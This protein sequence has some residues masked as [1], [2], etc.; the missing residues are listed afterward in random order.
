MSFYIVTL[1]FNNDIPK[2]KSQQTKL[3]KEIYDR[4]FRIEWFIKS[5]SFDKKTDIKFKKNTAII[6]FYTNHVSKLSWA[7]SNATKAFKGS[8][9][10]NMYLNDLLK[11]DKLTITQKSITHLFKK[12]KK[13]YNND[14]L[15]C[16]TMKQKINLSDKYRK[17]VKISINKF[18]KTLK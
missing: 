5:I 11:C 2:S 13:N 18:K 17:N 8:K 1:N 15:N 3:I 7:K 4:A 14:Y 6:T 10:G 12:L 9:F 16:T